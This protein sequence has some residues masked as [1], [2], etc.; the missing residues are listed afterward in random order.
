MKELDKIFENY[1]VLDVTKLQNN[2]TLAQKNDT[3]HA[4]SPTISLA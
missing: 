3:S 1:G 2:G 4:I